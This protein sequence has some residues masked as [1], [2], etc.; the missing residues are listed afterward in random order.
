MLVLWFST[1]YLLKTHRKKWHSIITAVPALFKSG[2]S[3]TYILMAPEGFS[4]SAE[5]SYTCGIIFV[6]CLGLLYI[7]GYIK[8][9]IREKNKIQKKDMC[10]ND[11]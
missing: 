8:L 6:V 5:I 2:V 4:L 7:N 1:A 3:S 9:S 10:N 11:K